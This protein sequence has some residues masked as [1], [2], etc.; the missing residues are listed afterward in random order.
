MKFIAYLL[1]YAFY[2][3]SFLFIRKK[4]KYA[5]GSSLGSFNGN[6]KSLFIYTCQHK[7]EI[8]A[9]WLTLSPTTLNQIRSMGLSVLS[10]ISLR[11]P[12]RSGIKKQIGWMCSII[13]SHSESPNMCCRQLRF[14]RISSQPHSVSTLM[15]ASHSAIRGTKSSSAQRRREGSILRGSAVHR[16]RSCWKECWQPVRCWFICLLGAIRNLAFLP[17]VW[18]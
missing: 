3:F 2:P 7:P 15:C 9:V 8:D 14:K 6:A 4:T 1:T 5:F 17:R 18:I 13:L 16:H 10:I 12:W 11:V